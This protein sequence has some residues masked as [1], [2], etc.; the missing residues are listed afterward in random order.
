MTDEGKNWTMAEIT[1]EKIASCALNRIFGFEPRLGLALIDY[2]GSAEAV[3]RMDR[4]KIRE[5]MGPYWKY[6]SQIGQ[7]VL[8]SAQDELE[9]IYEEGSEFLGIGDPLYPAMLKECDD[10]PI[11]LY[12]RGDDIVSNIFGYK[13]AVA[14]VGTRDMTPYGQEWCRRMVERMAAS[15]AKPVIVS[16]LAYGIDITAHNAALEY[17]LP[18]IAA[19]A[20]GIDAVYP[21]RHI[22]TADRIVSSPGSAL[23]TDYP[24][25]TVPLAIHFMRR[26]RIIAGLAHSVIVVESKEKGGSL[27]TARL[28]GSYSRDVYALPGRIDDMNSRGCNM[29][30]REKLAEPVTDPE[31]LVEKLGLGKSGPVRKTDWVATIREAYG[32]DGQAKVEEIESVAMVIKRNRG[33]DLQGICRETMLSYGTVAGIVEVLA[34]DGYISIDLVGHC[35]VMK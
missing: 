16:G 18:T 27:I 14:I 8:D 3:F 31:D 28:A 10:P 5:A 1:E 20:T 29:I 35:S 22:S 19:M 34:A 7:A 26:N 13:A 25:G 9:G 23:V 21:Q 33:I 12:V 6:I 17:G 32:K 24:V 30:I 2:A 15:P 11:G 4:E